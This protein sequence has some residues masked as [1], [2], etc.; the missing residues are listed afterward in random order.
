MHA[1]QN[2]SKIDCERFGTELGAHLEGD[3]RPFIAQ[4][5]MDCQGC[6]ALLADLQWIQSAARELP[7]EDPSSE[8]W[9]RLHAVLAAENQA[10]ESACARFSLEVERYLE[11][12]APPFLISHAQSCTSCHALLS[13]MQAIQVAARDLA[14]E[15]PSPALWGKVRESLRSEGVIVASPCLQFSDALAGYLEGETQPLVLSHAQEC[16]GCNSLLTELQTLQVAARELPFEEP[17][18]EAWPKLR[19]SLIRENLL[20]PAVCVRFSAEV[21][22]YLEGTAQPFVASHAR[23]CAPCGALLADL[24]MIREAA[25]N[26][27]EA[28][29]SRAVWANVHARLESEGAFTAPR[30]GWRDFLRLLSQPVP[31]TVLAGVIVFGIFLSAPF[32]R[33]TSRNGTPEAK[34]DT[35]ST[36]EAALTP[37][38]EDVPVAHVVSDLENN[39]KANEDSMNP[40]LKATYDK[41]LVSLDSSIQ[42]CLDSLHQEPGNTMAHDYLLTAYTRKAEVLSSA[43]EFEG[44]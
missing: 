33:L 3:P 13:D 22:Q 14:H 15:E 19:A 23:E 4:H 11:G 28:E 43:L 32:H 30:R 24:E 6:S 40:D 29:P 5:S 16:A 37:P 17:S 20:V 27:P 10:R 8:V 36:Q 42:E 26:L 18:A 25:R 12:D 44:R 41:S 31:L 2:N 9:T 7:D 1:Y 21:E 34:L 38:A 39:F 35:T